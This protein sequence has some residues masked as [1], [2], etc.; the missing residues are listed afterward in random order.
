MATEWRHKDDKHGGFKKGLVAQSII[1]LTLIGEGMQVQKTSRK[2]DQAGIDF[3]VF[4]KGKKFSLAVSSTWIDIVAPNYCRFLFCP[5]KN[6]K[7]PGVKYSQSQIFINYN[8]AYK[9]NLFLT[10]KNEIEKYVQLKYQKN[11]QNENFVTS[12]DESLS[13]GL[14]QLRTSKNVNLSSIWILMPITLMRK[15]VRNKYSYDHLDA[16]LKKEDLFS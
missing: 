3:E 2:I 15:A 10:T 12:V 13:T 16:E 1:K 9:D 5:Y 6:S 11:I 4:Y 7:I 14:P 8:C